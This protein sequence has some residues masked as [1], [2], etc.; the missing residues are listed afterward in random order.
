M[1]RGNAESLSKK[2]DEVQAKEREAPAEGKGLREGRS[3]AF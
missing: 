2:Q 3:Y 1:A